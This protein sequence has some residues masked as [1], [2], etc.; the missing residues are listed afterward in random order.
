LIFNDISIINGTWSDGVEVP[1]DASFEWLVSQKTFDF[2][3]LLHIHSV[4]LTSLE[5][6]QLALERCQSERKGIILTVHDTKP[7]FSQDLAMYNLALKTCV[8]AGARI[9]TLTK[10]AAKEIVKNLEVASS[11]IAVIP[12]GAVL[13]IDDHRW[14]TRRRTQNS[15]TCILGMYGGFRPNRDFLTPVVNIAFGM[16][17]LD[18]KLI[19]LTRAISPIELRQNEE[20]RRSIDIAISSNRINLRVYPFPSD[21]QIAQFLLDVSILIMP[22]RWGTHSGQLEAAFDLGVVPV[23]S[24]VGYYYEQYDQLRE[25]VEEPVWFNWSDSNEYAYGARLLEALYQGLERAQNIQDSRERLH[26]QRI[27]EHQEILSSYCSLY[28]LAVQGAK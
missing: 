7:N 25:F 4:E 12:H 11:D 15:S 1:R 14:Y 18:V 9:V 24:D 6:L 26:R 23:I 5:T 10:S 17:E 21:E 19:L 2:F 27:I 16:P 28:Q 22:Y 3:D 13:S 20:M 8:E